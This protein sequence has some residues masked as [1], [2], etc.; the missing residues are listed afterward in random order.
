MSEN[1]ASQ[2]RKPWAEVSASDKSLE[3]ELHKE[4]GSKHQ[5]YG[6]R[7]R[8]LARRLDND[9]VLFQVTGGAAPY[10]VVHLSWSSKMEQSPAWPAT[11]TYPTLDDWLA[12]AMTPGALGAATPK[13]TR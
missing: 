1:L 6:K 3:A 9:D 4:V 5:L 7:V 13:P 12:Q 8:A 10:A 11:T 2:L